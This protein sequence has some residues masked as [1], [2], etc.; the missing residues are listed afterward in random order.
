LLLLLLCVQHLLVVLDSL[1]LLVTSLA[2]TVSGRK[3]R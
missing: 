2:A 3:W 1:S